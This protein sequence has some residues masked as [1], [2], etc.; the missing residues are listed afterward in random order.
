MTDD[1]HTMRP[2]A[3]RGEIKD[4][5]SGGR[6]VHSRLIMPTGKTS[7]RLAMVALAAA[8]PVVLVDEN[9]MTTP[10]DGRSTRAPN[11]AWNHRQGAMG[12]G[13]KNKGIK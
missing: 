11:D 13:R 8:G 3:R 12:R 5:P 6:T 10:K 9:S 1:D 2:H 4:S 7:V